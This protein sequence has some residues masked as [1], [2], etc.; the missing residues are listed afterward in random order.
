MVTRETPQSVIPTY[1]ISE[2]V[3]TLKATFFSC[4]VNRL[5][6]YD[7]YTPNDLK[8]ARIHVILIPQAHPDTIKATFFAGQ[9]NRFV[10]ITYYYTPNDLK[11]M[12]VSTSIL[13]PKP[14]RHDTSK[15][16]ILIDVFYFF[17]S[18]KSFVYFSRYIIYTK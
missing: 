1:I 10:Y 5:C 3:Q 15:A 2:R 16:K 12:P 14:P 18:N 17:W 13:T 6:I 8:I 4:Q 11:I 9:V 7:Y